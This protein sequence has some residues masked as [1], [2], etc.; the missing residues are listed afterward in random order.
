MAAEPKSGTSTGTDKDRVEELEERVRQLEAEFESSGSS[1]RKRS[2]ED[3]KRTLQRLEEELKEIEEEER[4]LRLQR[5]DLLEALAEEADSDDPDRERLREFRA[6]L[7]RLDRRQ[8]EV[9]VRRAEVMRDIDAEYREIAR[10]PVSA[11]YRRRRER[12]REETLEPLEPLP[13]LDPV[14]SDP[15]VGGVNPITRV[16]SESGRLGNAVVLGH[17]G[18]LGATAEA[19]SALTEDLYTRAVARADRPTEMAM[20]MPADLSAGLWTAAD[21]LA[22]APRR[23]V[24]AM[25]SGYDAARR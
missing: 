12:L 23:A 9:Y 7:R 4:Q 8:R 17:L 20:T 19:M 14:T 2:S 3:P 15:F 6:Q 25:Y 11:G 22:T 5:P 1:D 16:V 13:A 10:R 21:R 24:D 18:L